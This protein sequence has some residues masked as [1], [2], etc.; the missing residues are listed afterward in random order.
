[1]EGENEEVLTEEEK[2][3]DILGKKPIEQEYV[4]IQFCYCS[5]KN[6]AT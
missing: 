6:C 5:G 1:M 2:K 3:E 4:L